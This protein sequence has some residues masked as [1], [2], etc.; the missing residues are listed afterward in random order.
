MCWHNH[1]KS[2]PETKR[3][4]SVQM[5]MAPQ[6]HH[7]H[8]LFAA[9]LRKLFL[10]HLSTYRHYWYVNFSTSSKRKNFFAIFA[11]VYIILQQ[12]HSVFYEQIENLQVDGNPVWDTL[13]ILYRKRIFACILHRK[14]RSDVEHCPLQLLHNKSDIFRH[15]NEKSP[16]QLINNWSIMW[17]KYW[18]MICIPRTNSASISLLAFHENQHQRDHS[19][20]P[21]PL[22]A[23]TCCLHT[24]H[25]VRR[26]L[27]I[28]S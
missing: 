28:N 11:G 16:T 18:L 5:A 8:R 14:M 17:V 4:C 21:R 23:K 9:Y 1:F 22:F 25:A 12:F 26:F 13:L 15:F 3:A 6:P 2:Q 7:L 10:L 27:P 20:G 24:V 19:T